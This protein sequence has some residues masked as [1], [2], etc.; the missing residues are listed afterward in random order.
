MPCRSFVAALL[1]TLLV[2][3]F[4]PSSAYAVPPRAGGGGSSTGGTSSAWHALFEQGRQAHD[5][6]R[7]E[8]AA[9]AF[10]GAH[11]AGG[12]P[13]LL[14]NYALCL[15]RLGRY[16]DAL[17]AYHA[18]LQEVPAAANRAD[19]EARMAALEPADIESGGSGLATTIA[20]PSGPVM[21]ILPPEGGF[22]MV[23]VGQGRPVTHTGPT[24]PQVEEIGPEWVVSW[25][26]LL[27]TLGS[28]GAAI[29]VWIDGQSTFDLLR[30]DCA[31][32]GGCAESDIAASSAHTSAT[33][34]NVL[35]VTTA[36]LGVATAI[37]FL[38][39]GTSTGGTRVYVDLG[40][41]SLHL[42][43]SF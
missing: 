16:E 35:L 20:P 1:T 37:S 36:V 24:G 13:S 5:Q 12:P 8:E 28:A 3:T 17:I 2:V 29:G 4:V 43:G 32:V 21:Q 26:F 11:D 25:F 14:Y 39:E 15:D 19:V 22:E 23:V 9:T 27:G 10:R 6:G 31:A 42:R 34:T 40:P 38:V 7:Y 41:G 33:V 30:E 18:Y